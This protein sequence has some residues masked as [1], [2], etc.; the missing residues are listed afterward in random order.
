M[1]YDTPIGNTLKR[2]E[3]NKYR[4][5]EPYDEPDDYKPRKKKPYKRSKEKL[6]EGILCQP[7]T[8]E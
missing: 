4:E 1:R 7:K 2:K 6:I 5:I 8:E 3:L